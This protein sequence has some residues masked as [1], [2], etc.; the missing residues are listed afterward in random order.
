M[1]LL[2]ADFM[3]SFFSLPTFHI[4]NKENYHFIQNSKENYLKSQKK[5]RFRWK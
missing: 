1:F 3:N 2:K 4:K 5:E